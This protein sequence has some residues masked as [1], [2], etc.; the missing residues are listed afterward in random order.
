MEPHL[1]LQVLYDALNLGGIDIPDIAQRY[2]ALQK[3]IFH[4]I[5]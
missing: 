2:A 5:I 1:A 3:V 4:S